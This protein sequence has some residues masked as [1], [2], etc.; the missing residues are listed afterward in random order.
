MNNTDISKLLKLIIND[1]T[2]KEGISGID[3]FKE[4][5]KH[6]KYNEK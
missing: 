2:P 3:N 5:F 6:N 1:E 4:I